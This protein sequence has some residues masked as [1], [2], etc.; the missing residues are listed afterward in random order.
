[1]ESNKYRACAGARRDRS[2]RDGSKRPGGT[3]AVRGKTRPK[4]ERRKV[5]SG[6]PHASDGC[7]ADPFGHSP[8]PRGRFFTRPGTCC[9]RCGAD[10]RE[11][12]SALVW[13][14]I[15]VTRWKLM[16]GRGW[17]SSRGPHAIGRRGG[18]IRRIVC[19]FE[20]MELIAA[21]NVFVGR[22]NHFWKWLITWAL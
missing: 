9:A 12:L 6:R 15:D 5:S 3:A 1:M 11:G 16:R 14:S 19:T 20:Q 22:R 2:A 13:G 7:P 17:F 18:L 10:P 8:A 21:R 4:L